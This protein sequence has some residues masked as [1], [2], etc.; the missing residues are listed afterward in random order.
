[1]DTSHRFNPSKLNQL[2][3]AACYRPIELH[4]VV[5]CESCNKEAKLTNVNGIWMCPSCLDREL[6]VVPS[7][8]SQPE[9]IETEQSIASEINKDTRPTEL[10][11]SAINRLGS[12][13]ISKS[14]D[15]FNAQT[16]SF[17]SRWAEIV[18]DDTI[19]A[20]NKHYTM[21]KEVRAFYLNM[22]SVLFQAVEIQL[23]C[24]AKQRS[25]QIY[26]NQLASKLREEER[27]KLHLANIDYVPPTPK[28]APKSVRV[29]KDDKMASM[30]AKIMGIPIETA[31]RLI[32]NKLKEIVG[33]CTCAE[34]PGVCLIHSK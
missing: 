13:S 31:R 34:T 23:E 14:E 8:K 28:S 6:E 1:M 25:S 11:H 19:G 29:S 32:D 9:K 17:A 27:V 30:Y 12:Q 33:P 3:C 5:T 24:A 18:A 16:R 22:K 21:A 20:E 10:E 26:L 4:G 2:L 15:F 7:I